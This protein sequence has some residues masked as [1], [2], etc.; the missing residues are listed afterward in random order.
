MIDPTY[1]I[2]QQDLISDKFKDSY[3]NF[4]TRNNLQNFNIPLVGCAVGLPTL[5]NTVTY[6]YVTRRL[7]ISPAEMKY[8]DKIKAAGEIGKKIDK[9]KDRK[10]VLKLK[11]KLNLDFDFPEEISLR[12]L[13]DILLINYLEN[14]NN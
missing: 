13:K 8:E 4:I 3:Q 7:Y 1:I 6:N 5:D 12:E 14:G 9:E 10:E 11:E 2:G